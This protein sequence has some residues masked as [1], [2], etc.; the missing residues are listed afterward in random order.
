[1]L[2]DSAPATVI[3]S[4]QPAPDHHYLAQLTRGFRRLRFGAALEAE[5][6]RTLE[7]EQRRSALIC[8]AMTLLIWLGF[9][10][11]DVVRIGITGPLPVAPALWFVLVSRWGLLVLLAAFCL[12]PALWHVP[13]R[14][15]AFTVYALIGIVSAVNGVIYKAQGIPSVDT[16]LVVVVMAA[17]LPLGM[18]FFRALA[19]ALLL[20]LVTA[21]AG[22]LLFDSSQM[23][24]HLGL[25]LVMAIAAAVGAA[26]GYLR[27]HTHRQQF[28]LN[29]ILSRQAQFDPLTDLANRR[30]FQ[31]HAEAA[32][33]H[34]ARHDEPP[35][36]AILDIDHFKSFN[37]RFGHAA[38][39]LALCKV[40][41]VLRGAARR[42][43]D[44]A[45]RIGG[46]EFAL[47]LYGCDLAK[48]ES[49]LETVRSRVVD[50][51]LDQLDAARLTISGGATGP[52]AG[53][54]LSD[55]YHRADRLLYASKTAGRNR[56]SIG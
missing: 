52:E 47:L 11:S 37:D 50:I 30:L 31:R 43:M 56:I 32:I 12:H 17:F 55:L 13:I 54:V 35:V 51:S 49:V 38:G 21:A 2:S 24:G 45:A 29:A 36:L 33:A 3:A 22:L 34:A 53:E 8:A 5:Y 41:D 42:P 27:E 26:G 18:T 23:P 48:A 39:D 4:A 40:A 15:A 10:I 6:R 9:A 1:M 20:V 14:H 28:L 44:L 25:V 19:A 16:A 46:E 7:V